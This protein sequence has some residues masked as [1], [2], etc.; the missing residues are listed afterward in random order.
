MV[1]T[2]LG[3]YL[4]IM[5]SINAILFLAQS[6]ITDINP[7]GPNFL[8][9][10]LSPLGQF[11]NDDGGLIINASAIGIDVEEPVETTGTNVFTDAFKKVKQWWNK[12]DRNFGFLTGMLKQPYGFMLQIGIHPAICVA[13]GTI[14]YVFIAFLIAGFITGRNT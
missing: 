7:E 14:W 12:L 2:K 8:D 5:F 4:V 13:F 1:D 9:I 11:L 3:T 10:S 6:S